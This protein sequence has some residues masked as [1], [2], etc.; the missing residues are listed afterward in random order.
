MEKPRVWILG[1]ADPE[2]EMIEALLRE[3]G[4]RVVH[5]TVD[6]RRVHPGNAYRADIPQQREPL[7]VAGTVYLVE[8]DG[9]RWQQ[10]DDDGEPA[11]VRIDHHRPGDGGYGRPPSEFLSASSI[12]Q[13]IAELARLGRLPMWLGTQDNSPGT[14]GREVGEWTDSISRGARASACGEDAGEPPAIVTE[15]DDGEGEGP[16]VR[17][18]PYELVLT[19]AADH[20]LA[21]AYRGECPGVDPDALMRWRAET[22]AAFQKRSVED[23]LADVERAREALRAAPQIDL[24]TSFVGCDYHGEHQAG[25]GDCWIDSITVRDLRD[26]SVPELPEA[27]AREGAVYLA[28]VK[29][30]DGRPKV[31]LGGAAAP[32]TVR[33]FLNSWAPAQGLTDIYGDPARCFAGGYLP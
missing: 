15:S 20:C 9:E 24:V 13:V 3:C 7:G 16:Y 4:E 22:R 10:G 21:A 27:A 29:D 26:R 17:L 18:V 8:C 25:C 6:G 19:A 31:V 32:E 11:V 2:M 30:R 33:A 5:A 23:L 14:V 28:T 12:G 1:A